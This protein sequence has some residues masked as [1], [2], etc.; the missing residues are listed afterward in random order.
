MH[1]GKICQLKGPF[2]A[3]VN[4]LGSNT[5]TMKIGISIDRKDLMPFDNK[6]KYSSGFSFS[7]NGELIEMGR[8]G[9]YESSGY[10]LITSLSF[11]YDT[12]ESVIVNYVTGE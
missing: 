5:G 4:V 7:V 6:K 9:M 8:T 3:G 1:E 2:K 11:T 10:T 12:P